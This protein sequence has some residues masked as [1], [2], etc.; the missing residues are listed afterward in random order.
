M[1]AREDILHL[2]NMYGFTIDTGDLDGFAGLFEHGE[3]GM[4]GTK[5]FVGKQEFREALSNIIIYEDGTPRTK[6]VTANIDLS[7]DKKSGKARSQCYVTVFQQTDEFPL[8]A[9]F[10]GHYF[11]EFRRVR[12]KWRFK[13]RHIRYRLVGDM[14]A[15]LKTVSDIVPGNGNSA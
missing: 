12:G 5:P 7:I 15:H 6:H 13:K 3:W 1:S 14:T 10:S 4:E 2:I 8:Q 9:I 11:D